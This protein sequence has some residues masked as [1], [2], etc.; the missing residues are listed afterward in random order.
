MLRLGSAL[1][2]ITTL[3]F[4]SFSASTHDALQNYSIGPGATNSA[5]SNTYSLQ[6]TVGEQ[7]NGT[8]S[9]STYTA[10]NGSVQTEQLNVPPAPTLSNGSNTYYNKLNLIVNAGSNPADTTFAVAASTDNFTTTN[11]VQADGTLN[12]TPVYQ[13]ASTW[14]NSG[15][16]TFMIGLTPSTSYEVKVAAKQGQFTNTEYGAYATASTVAP[17]I[18]FS[19]SP[20]STN[21]GN[22]LPGSVVTSSNLSFTFA[23][24]AASGGNVYVSGQHNGLLSALQSHTIAAFSGNLAGQSEGFGVQAT[25][26]N[27][28]SGGPL[29]T[30]SPFN[31]TSNTVGAESTVPQAMLTT[32]NPIVSGTANANLQAKASSTTPASTDY[33]E[34][35]TFIASASF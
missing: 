3:I 22:L 24:N 20:N 26:P 14:N 4:A 19:V 27:Q 5:A 2:G 18:T 35:L 10:N 29:S 30:V 17:A 16:G 8:T 31:G 34:V 6:G 7:A 12:T 11:Y 13:L 21:L 1:L 15:L 28:S 9:G 23:T 33:Q 25:N 32:A